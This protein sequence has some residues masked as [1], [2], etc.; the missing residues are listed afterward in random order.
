MTFN[1]IKLEMICNMS[2][3]CISV[4]FF[5]LFHSI[6]VYALFGPNS[7]MLFLILQYFPGARHFVTAYAKDIK[8]K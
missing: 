7:K 2:I 3:F 8:G 1:S 4:C 6:C 5:F